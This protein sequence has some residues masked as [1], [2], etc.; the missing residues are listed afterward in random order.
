MTPSTMI[1][2]DLVIIV[3]AEI[4]GEVE[5]CETDTLEDVRHKIDDE[6]EDDMM[7][8]FEDDCFCFHVN[9]GIRISEKQECKKQ[10]WNLTNIRL[11]SKSNS[12]FTKQG[13]KRKLESSNSSQE[14]STAGTKRS[15]NE[16]EDN[17]NVTPA[18]ASAPL[19][20]SSRKSP[21]VEESPNTSNAGHTTTKTNDS[22]TSAVAM[23]QGGET[24]CVGPPP[25]NPPRQQEDET[26]YPMEDEID[27]AEQQSEGNDVHSDVDYYK[28]K[29]CI[30]SLYTIVRI[31]RVDLVSRLS[32][33]SFLTCV[34]VYVR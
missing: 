30:W 16:N 2:K 26:E 8:P 7:I 20:C 14:Q 4:K 29:V 31:C 6:F 22:S 5:I 10:A 34:C 28:R 18:S 33:S 24:P 3:S 13:T 17:H 19:A 27:Q 21:P 23:D 25:G 12:K 32:C 9:D 11:H 15:K 1:K